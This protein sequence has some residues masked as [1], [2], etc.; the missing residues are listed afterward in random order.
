MKKKQEIKAGE[1][2]IMA[3]SRKFSTLNIP[4]WAAALVFAAFTL[5]FFWD[6]L[7][8]NRFFWEDFL[9]YI[10]PTQS[11]AAREFANG[12]IPFWNPYTFNGMP[13]IADLQTGFFYPLNRLLSLFVGAEGK[14]SVS[15]LQFVTIMHF[16]IAQISMFALGKKLKISSIGSIISAVSY[17]FSFLLVLHVIHPMILAHLSWFPL[18]IMLLISAMNE[19]S[20]RK[21]IGAGAL[22]GMSM[23]SGHPQLTLYELFFLGLL[24]LWYLGAEIKSG[25]FK[26]NQPVRF[27]LATALVFIMAAGIFQIQYLPS[28]E[29]A[30]LSVRNEMTYEKAAE[31]SMEFSQLFT[32]VI[33]NLYGYSNGSGI[34]N[35]PYYLQTED[36]TGK[37]ITT[38]YFFYWETGFYFGIA[39]LM[40]G[41]FGFMTMYKSRMG[42]FLLAF[43]L[44]AIVFALGKN[45]FLF[46]LFHS[47]P[48]FSA[49]RNP[50]RMMFAVSLAM[51]IMAG[52]GF[53]KL[54]FGES[55]KNM[56]LKFLISAAIPALVALLTIGGIIPSSINT[57]QNVIDFVTAYGTTAL[58]FT[59]GFALLAWLAYIKKVNPIIPGALIVLL[60]FADLYYA[61]GDFNKSEISIAASYDLPAETL[62][63]F[64]PKLPN[65]IFR[66]NMRMYNPSYMA[67]KRNQGL[68]DGIMLV[69]GY[70]P[71]VL[72]KVVPPLNSKDEI[73]KLYNVKWEIGIDSVRRM[74][75]FLEKKDRLPRAWMVFDAVYSQTDAVEKNMRNTPRD[76]S[77]I[78][79]LEENM[80]FNM[81]GN[82][83]SSSVKAVCLSY[84][85]NAFKYKV[86]SPKNGALVF[87][88]IYYPAWKAYQDGKE[89]KVYRANYCLRAVP[90][91]KGE[92]IIEMRYESDTFSKGMWITL[93]TLLGGAVIFIFGANKNNFKNDDQNQE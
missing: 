15:M 16:F 44:F 79:V 86:N 21:G 88:E 6:Q 12:V 62:A 10:Y 40:L 42:A 57:P 72:K 14:L 11:F 33:P 27:I 35:I 20:I 61:G 90:V 28:K 63:A 8:G 30:D 83:D 24:G 50:A 1:T 71:L 64:K 19:R 60:A 17:S 92:H 41:L 65:D 73:H 93:I 32:S 22:M 56:L 80:P 43:T 91:T 52:M 5:F 78:V 23:L 29:L 68:V 49:F 81:P 3:S 55:N 67:T 82:A 53:D 76:Y 66:V 45:G 31:G 85:N 75:V 4:Y 46:G 34:T 47:L 77:Q 37:A 84:K 87:S 69:E 74:P 48:L 18:V 51:S 58:W 39:A 9:E 25:N 7:N 36:T 59:L 2:S 70:N 89:I 26:T 13:F 38:P 54:S